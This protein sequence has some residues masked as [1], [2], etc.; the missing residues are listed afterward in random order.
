MLIW[1]T[2]FKPVRGFLF[3]REEYL[4]AFKAS[5]KV[6]ESKYQNKAEVD[7][8][9]NVP[10]LIEPKIPHQEKDTVILKSEQKVCDDMKTVPNDTVKM[11]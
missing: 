8:K 10:E 5:L 4:K 2:L 6:S 1:A 7:Q 11:P 9:K 3:Q